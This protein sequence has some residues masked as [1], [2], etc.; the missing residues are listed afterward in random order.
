MDTSHRVAA[1]TVARQI[2]LDSRMG[3]HRLREAAARFS[4]ADVEASQSGR[5]RVDRFL[6]MLAP[7]LSLSNELIPLRPVMATQGFDVYETDEGA[8][9]S[10]RD[11]REF[12]ASLR[13]RRLELE[14]ATAGDRLSEFAEHYPVLPFAELTET[15]TRRLDA[16]AEQLEADLIDRALALCHSALVAVGDPEH[17]LTP[18]RLDNVMGDVRRALRFPGDHRGVAFSSEGSVSWPT[19]ARSEDPVAV[20]AESTTGTPDATVEMIR[21]LLT[22]VDLSSPAL[23]FERSTLS[24]VELAD[25]NT[26]LHLAQDAFRG[27][28]PGD[29][30]VFLAFRYAAHASLLR[31]FEDPEALELL[32]E[33]A[34]AQG[35]TRLAALS[36]THAYH[37]RDQGRGPGLHDA[38]ERLFSS[39]PQ[40]LHLRYPSLF[41]RRHHWV[42]QLMAEFDGDSQD[43]RAFRDWALGRV[44]QEL[45]GE[46]L[47]LSTHEISQLGEL[48]GVV[49][50]AARLDGLENAVTLTALRTL[51]QRLAPLRPQGNYDELLREV[52]ERLR[53]LSSRP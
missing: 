49:L 35:Y 9:A 7:G 10:T 30:Q 42:P 8:E 18:D 52:D 25:A 27:D 51:Y 39:Y 47:P 38:L 14:S 33:T 19:R 6:E 37:L 44:Q 22:E 36:L 23:R 13:A 21:E 16:M 29:R 50:G 48:A 26:L 17:Y 41:G 24:D 5:R 2:A 53:E 12:M 28:P 43:P 20:I 1:R 32:A 11:L 45:P 3:Q 46:E 31:S 15:A 40:D 4:L 34:A